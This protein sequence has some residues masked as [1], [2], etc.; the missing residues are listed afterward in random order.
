MSQASHW[1]IVREP[2]I[3]HLIITKRT[4]DYNWKYH[5]ARAVGVICLVGLSKWW[6]FQTLERW[7]TISGKIFIILFRRL[8]WLSKLLYALMSTTVQAGSHG[9]VFEGSY[10]QILFVSPK[11]CAYSK[12]L[13]RNKN[14]TFALLKM[15]FAPLNLKTWLWAC[16][17][18][19]QTNEKCEDMNSVKTFFWFIWPP[20]LSYGKTGLKAAAFI[21]CLIDFLWRRVSKKAAAVRRSYIMVFATNVPH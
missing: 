17:F 6:D 5:D 7:R 2:L 4:L 20:S 15:N 9:V 14:K 8:L 3:C 10:T 21:Q 1:R 16:N 13:F 12:Y 18:V 19:K 11:F